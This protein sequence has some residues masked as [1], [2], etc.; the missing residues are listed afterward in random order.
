MPEIVETLRAELGDAVRGDAET[1]AAHRRDS[2]VLSEL[3]DLE[4]R[5][6]PEPLAVVVPTRTEEVS[7]TLALCRAAGVPV[8]PYGGGSGVCGAI[9]VPEGAVVLSTEALTGLVSIDDRSLLATFRAGTNGLEAEQTVREHGLTIGHW[10]QSIALSTVG[11]WVATRASGQYSTGYGNIEDVILD[12]EI[13]LPDGRILRTRR[14]PRA[15]AGPD[16]RQLFLGSEGT[17]GVVTEVTF[18]LRP[19]PEASRGQAFHFASLPAGLEP[20]RQLVRAGWRPPVTRLYDEIESKRHFEEACP[21]GRS[22]LLLLH[23]GPAALVDVEIPAVADLCRA[24]GGGEADPGL[25]DHWLETRNHV[26]G[27]RGFLERGIVL[28]TLEVACTWDLAPALYER[29][30]AALREVP[31]NLVASAHSSHSYRSGTCLY[32]TF[33]CRP[34]RREQMADAYRESWR[35][36]MEAVIAV[37]GGIAHHHGIGRVRCGVMAD[38][39]GETGVA[40]LRSV[41]RALD[42][43]GLCN[44]GVLLDDES[45]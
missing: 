14:T 31:G 18:S 40:L 7:R 5:P 33:A 38:E 24:A 22:M 16:L 44:P 21:E 32:I 27:F 1:L 4:E 41:R 30:T 2:W 45:R 20:I 6:G 13:V 19:L 12:L 43:E 11:G 3:A 35:R 8:V 42:P 9:L 25:V 28:D 15:S 17:L 39:L 36:A 10:P 37:G 26:P 34:E 23:E 29:A